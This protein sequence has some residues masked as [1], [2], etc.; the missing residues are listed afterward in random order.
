MTGSDIL[1]DSSSWLAYLSASDNRQIKNILDGKFKIFT[2]AVSFFEIRKKLLRE[3]IT[4]KNISKFLEFIRIRS[5]VLDVNE[6]ICVSAADCS[7]K[8]GLHSVDSII[9]ASALSNHCR[10][11]T[12]DNDF[13]KIENAEVLN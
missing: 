1:L 7:I 4:E 3:K 11:L 10:L 8:Y 12:F 13:R 9:Y 5:M 2:S 6:K